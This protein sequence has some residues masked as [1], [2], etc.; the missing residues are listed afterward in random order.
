MQTSRVYLGFDPNSSHCR[1]ARPLLR[2]ALL[3][4]IPSTSIA[5]LHAKSARHTAAYPSEEQ[6][7]MESSLVGEGTGT[8]LGRGTHGCY[9]A[10]VPH[11]A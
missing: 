2:G 6:G 5:M 1:P 9:I 11:M 3:E 8:G 4:Q 7:I 10:L